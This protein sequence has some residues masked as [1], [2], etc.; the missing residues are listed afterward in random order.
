[1]SV[2]TLAHRGWAA[3]QHRSLPISQAAIPSTSDAGGGFAVSFPAKHL[4]FGLTLSRRS[5]VKVNFS[6]HLLLQ[7]LEL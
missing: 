7:S 6:L 1:V 3:V 5:S 4:T 2:F